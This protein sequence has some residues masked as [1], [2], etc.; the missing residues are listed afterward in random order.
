MT[1]VFYCGIIDGNMSVG[2]NNK[3]VFQNDKIVIN[4]GFLYDYSSEMNYSD[5]KMTYY[6][7]ILPKVKFVMNDNSVFKMNTQTSHTENQPTARNIGK[8]RQSNIT[9]PEQYAKNYANMQV[10]VRQSSRAMN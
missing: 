1:D 9:Q 8:K 5:I 10:N 7:T 6:S 2:G 3:V 4:G